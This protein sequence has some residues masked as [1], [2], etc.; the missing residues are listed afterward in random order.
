ME[1]QGICVDVDELV[2]VYRSRMTREK[3]REVLIAWQKKPKADWVDEH[4][5]RDGETRL[6]GGFTPD[7]LEA[8]SWCKRNLVTVYDLINGD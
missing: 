7:E 3:A 4:W 6:D 5:M 2:E 8:I 1:N